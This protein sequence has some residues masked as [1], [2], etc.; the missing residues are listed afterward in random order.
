MN[1]SYLSKI[2]YV[3][4]ILLIAGLFVTCDSISDFG[5]MNEDPT[6]AN[7]IEPGMLLTTVQ[8]AAAGTRY[9]V[10]RAQLLYGSN[11]SQHT[12]N[13]FFGGG[14]NYTEV[15]DWLTAFWNTAYS[16]T[17]N[18]QRAQVKNIEGLIDQLEMRKEEGEEVGNMLATA[19]IMRV[20]IYHRITDLYGDAPYS[21]A[22]KGAIDQEFTPAYDTQEEIYND[23]FTELDEA[24]NQFDSSQ[25]MFGSNDL[26][27]GGD[28]TQWQKFGNSLRLRL[29]LRLV[30]VN[31]SK[32]ETEA[33]AAIDAPGGVMTSN[34]DIAMIQHQSGPSSG[35]AGLNTNA[36]SEAMNDGGDHEYVAQTM[37]DWLKNNND[38]RLSIYAETDSSAY[39][40]FPSGYTATSI[41]DHN[42]FNETTA[43]YARVN[44]MLIDLDD[45]TF[46]QTYAEVEFMLAELAAR[47]WTSDAAAT[48]YENGVR[49]AM[50]YLSLYDEEGGAD[51]ADSDINNYL[52][53]NPFNAGGSTGDK[54]EQINEQYWAAVFLNGIEAWSNWRRS[55]YPDL[56][57]ALVDS[58][59]PPAGNQTN[60]EIP[61][62]LIYPEG[63][64]GVLN[65]KNYDEVIERQGENDMVTRVWWDV[66]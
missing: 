51:I 15:V 28:I 59:D 64:E 23:M 16:G 37:V 30:K 54:L 63:T 53:N 19:R 32:A 31:E 39:V 5:D 11:V 41:Q 43:N 22:G 21:E 45:P 29:A 66:E 57:P 60:G 65:A 44:S 27:F 47:N 56:E 58:N 49:A 7:S 35:P 17:G 34:D 1:R 42:S 9:E 10:W 46:F 55:G 18:S 33:L 61:R 20:F 50:E 40:G 26:M 12:V 13:A 6:Q 2:K 48:H 52:A 62:R 3:V 24:V 4:S 38:P 36:I 14:N 8:L 25:P